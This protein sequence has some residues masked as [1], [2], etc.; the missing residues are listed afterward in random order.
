MDVCDTYKNIEMDL[1]ALSYIPKAIAE[2]YTVFPFQIKN[3]MLYLLGYKDLSHC[4]NELKFIC[5]LEIK[6]IICEKHIINQYIHKFYYETEA[7]KLME[8]NNYENVIMD[9]KHNYIVKNEPNNHLIDYILRDAIIKNVSDIHIEPLKE[10]VTVRYRIDGVIHSFTNILFNVY[11]ELIGKIKV[12]SN[13]DTTEKR[14]PQ[15]GKFKYNYNYN[16]FDIRVSTLPTVYGEKVVLRILNKCSINMDL[17][18]IGFDDKAISIIERNIKENKGMIVVTGPTGSGKSTTLY[19]ILNKIDKHH[20]NVIT[21]EDPVEYSI[22]GVNQV[23]INEKIGF[24]FLKALKH[25]L[26]QDPDVL[27]IGEIRDEET[28][29]MAIRAAITG[30]LVLTTL[31]TKDATSTVSRLI[32]M[33]IR[34]YLIADAINLIITQRLVRKVCP[35]CRG[36]KGCSKCSFT[37]FLGRTIIYEMMDMDESIRNMILK[38]FNTEK[39]KKYNL[40]KMGYDLK[41]NGY[42]LEKKGLTTLKEINAL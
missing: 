7:K 29:Q 18:S 24:T 30:H 26:R 41:T 4:I 35:Y 22:D 15:D 23:N 36:I 2:R 28:A 19:S 10:N 17:K 32:D 9:K 25:I 27:M 20:K 13:I 8:F 16:D 42:S 38:D 1:N 31:H 39:L 21:I 11:K 12:L 3:N 14:L 5:K 33:N 40:N 6:V 37:G 34:P